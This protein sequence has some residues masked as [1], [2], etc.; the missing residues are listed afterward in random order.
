MLGFKFSYRDQKNLGIYSKPQILALDDQAPQSSESNMNAF[1]APCAPW[2]LPQRNLTSFQTGAKKC[3]RAG[4]KRTPIACVSRAKVFKYGIEAAVEDYVKTG[5]NICIGDGNDEVLVPMLDAIASMVEVEG[6]VD[7][8]FLGS[9]P[10]TKS[11]LKERGLPSDTVVNFRSNVDLFLAPVGRVDGDCNAVLESSDMG[12]DRYAAQMA[13]KVVLIVHEDDMSEYKNGLESIPVKLVD[14]SPQ[15]AAQ[16]LCSDCLYMAGVRG[17][18]LRSGDENIAD[19]SISKSCIPVLLE[20]ELKQLAEVVAVGMLPAFDKT[21]IVVSTK[22]LQ[23]FDITPASYSFSRNVEDGRGDIVD[24]STVLD[25]V[26]KLGAG[27]TVS[28]EEGG[29]C[30]CGELKFDAT[31]AAD[32]MIRYMHFL[33]KNGGRF[34]ELRQRKNRVLV[35]LGGEKANKMRRADVMIA[36]MVAQ[37]YGGDN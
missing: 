32:G 13:D 17:A 3:Y 30:L 7:V 27:W 25:E 10:N 23:P 15:T 11:L 1:G 35:R 22:D 24:E 37:M 20:Q 19:V 8:A 4:G 36:K 18:S 31:E 33:R 14:F 29:L 9:N 28:A 26:K 12:G 6:L 34:D 2:V 16:S 5:M 21:T